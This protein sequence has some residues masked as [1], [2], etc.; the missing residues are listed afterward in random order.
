MRDCTV[1]RCCDVNE[2]LLDVSS[3]HHTVMSQCHISQHHDVTSAHHHSQCIITSHHNTFS[4]LS[5]RVSS[6]LLVVCSHNATSLYVAAQHISTMPRLITALRLIVSHHSSLSRCWAST[7]LITMSRLITSCYSSYPQCHI[8]SCLM[9]LRL[10]TL[11]HL[12]ITMSLGH[13]TSRRFSHFHT[14]LNQSAFSG[15]QFEM[16]VQLNVSLLHH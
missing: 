3:E 15:N 6:R 9:C 16:S 8:S 14:R 10:V 11:S 2:N 12:I 7:H 1:T 13:I 5:S 4:Q